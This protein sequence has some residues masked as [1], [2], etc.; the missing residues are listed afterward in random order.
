MMWEMGGYGIYVWP[1]Y[2]LVFIALA[3]LFFVSYKAEKNSKRQSK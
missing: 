2:A 1:S 3:G